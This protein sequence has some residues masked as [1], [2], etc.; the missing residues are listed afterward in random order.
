[1]N[2]ERYLEE[3]EHRR[4]VQYKYGS[5]EY[6]FPDT[7]RERIRAYTELFDIGENLRIGHD[8][9]F[10]RTHRLEGHI[11]IGCNVIFADE[12][13]IDYSGTLII[14]DQVT[15]SEGV[16]IYSH[17]HDLHKLSHREEDN[18]IPTETII[19]KGAWIGASAIIL[20]GVTIGEYAMVGAGAIVTRD[21][22]ANT[23]VG[24][25]PA[26]FIKTIDAV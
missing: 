3:Q 10:Y 8:V 21:V 9:Y 12:I 6:S 4:R 25:N 23:I 22:A 17:T 26:K 24:G 1:M 2:N 7:Y 18:A 15:I 19:R 14:E 11:L 20:P 5:K 13:T 16:K